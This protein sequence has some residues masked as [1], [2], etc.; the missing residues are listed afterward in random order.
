MRQVSRAVQALLRPQSIA[1]VG[2][3]SDPTALGSRLFATLQDHAFGGGLFAINRRA[4]PRADGGATYTSLSALPTIPDLCMLVVPSG[5]VRDVL[6]ECAELGV[7]SAVVCADG[8]FQSGEV[9]R[10]TRVVGP[11]SVGIYNRAHNMAATWSPVIRESTPESLPDGTIAVVAQS[12]GLGFGILSAL[13]ARGLGARYV[14]SCGNE[15][16]LDCIDLALGCLDDPDIRVLLMF[17]EGLHQPGRLLDLAARARALG[18]HIAVAKVGR[19]EAAQQAAELHTAHLAGA[20]AAYEAAFASTGIVRARDVAELVDVAQLLAYAPALRSAAVG[21]TSISGGSAVWL[22]DAC[23]EAGL[24]VPLLSDES[25]DGIRRATGTSGSTRNP[26]DVTGPRLEPDALAAS[27]RRLAAEP[28]IG[29][30]VVALS[31]A[32]SADSV[33]AIADIE[34]DA[35]KPIVA[36]DYAGDG[37]VLSS[38]EKKIPTFTSPVRLAEALRLVSH[39]L[40]IRPAYRTSGTDS[41]SAI[42]LE[43]EVKRRLQSYG[44]AFPDEQL[45]TSAPSAA[46]FAARY[47]SVALKAQAG[48]I[49]HKAR[50]G[51]VALDV[52][53]ADAAAVFERLVLR[54]RELT[55][56]DPEGVLIAEMLPAGLEMF[57]G[58]IVSG[59]FGPLIT[60]GLGGAHTELIGDR[61]VLLPPLQRDGVLSGMRRLRNAHAVAQACSASDLDAFVDTVERVAQFVVDSKDELA[62]VDLNPVTIIPGRG[63]LVVDASAT[64]AKSAA[65]DSPP[66]GQRPRVTRQEVRP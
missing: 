34:S 17:L 14:L 65:P 27:V 47:P 1:V 12:G 26:V 43:S 6:A 22:T 15:V 58:A 35:G 44:V 10:G 42:L 32:V 24:E 64:A 19:S 5:A 54:A 16:D 4:A 49:V 31:P 3:S 38:G 56:N 45:V 48:G 2:V 53:P 8:G 13:K 50:L 29:A 61:F 25:Q 62:G 59:E 20:D 40:P 57:V 9:H 66:G 52:A 11:N 55:G 28:A 18:K 30:V 37:R 46:D 63:A 39:R 60:I 41:G 21:I 23:V 33:A 36:F 51:L 7:P